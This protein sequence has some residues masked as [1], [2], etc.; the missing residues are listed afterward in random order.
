MSPVEKSQMC[1][2]ASDLCVDESPDRNQPQCVKCNKL[3]TIFALENTQEDHNNQQQPQAQKS[4]S[5]KSYISKRS[6]NNEAVVERDVEENAHISCKYIKARQDPTLRVRK[7]DLSRKNNER[8]FKCS[9][10]STKLQNTLLMHTRNI[11]TPAPTI[12]DPYDNAHTV[13]VRREIYA[14]V[15]VNAFNASGGDLRLPAQLV[16][17]VENLF[18][19]FCLADVED[20]FGA[21]FYALVA[22][23]LLFSLFVLVAVF[24]MCLSINSKELFCMFYYSAN[25]RIWANYSYNMFMRFK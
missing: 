19:E 24:F 3:V 20:F 7:A 14:A 8:V 16:N 21:K 2:G 11:S 23:V 4:P 5:S 1:N 15:V 12:R 13:F 6:I 17:S 10:L 25:I 22:V 18:Q 9:Q